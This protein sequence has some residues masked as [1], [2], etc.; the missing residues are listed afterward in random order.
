MTE[1]EALTKPETLS[2]A[3]SV[4]PVFD[5]AALFNQHKK[6]VVR[7]SDQ[8]NFGGNL[9]ENT[10]GS[11]FAIDYLANS[12]KTETGDQ[13]DS[14]ACR[15]AT[16]NHVVAH[17]SKDA[18]LELGNGNKYPFTVELRDEANDLAIVRVENVKKDDCHPLEITDQETP[19]KAGD[20]VLKMGAR[21][22]TPGFTEG[23]VETYF[24]R[25]EARGL[26]LLPGEDKNRTMLSA[27]TKTN[28]AQGGDSGGP[29]LDATGKT[30]GVMDAEGPSVM[31]GT[32]AHLLLQNLQKLKAN[33]K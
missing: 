33:D 4:T 10:V 13:K 28:Q 2:T 12:P 1:Q 15:F 21:Y 23:N 11:G 9:L 18:A 17:T 22:G 3:S 32:P 26:P 16:D 29:M 25:E 6:S 20:P 14:A 19:L 27:L 24:K 30:I 7:V 5:A 31:A 8:V